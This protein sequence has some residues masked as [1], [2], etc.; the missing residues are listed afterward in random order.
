MAGTDGI[1]P[2]ADPAVIQPES[3]E[4]FNTYIHN[5]PTEAISFAEQYAPLRG[6]EVPQ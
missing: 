6:V 5:V 1:H 3:L 2:V 4:P